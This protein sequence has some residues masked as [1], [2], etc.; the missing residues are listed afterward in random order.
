MEKQSS[1]DIGF[2][3]GMMKS[4]LGMEDLKNAW[5]WLRKPENAWARTGLGAIGGAG[6]GGMMGGTRGAVLG[7]LGGAGLGYAAPDIKDYLFENNILGMQDY[8]HNQ[9][10]ESKYPREQA[11]ADFENSLN[12]IEAQ[13]REA[14]L[15]KYVQQDREKIRQFWKAYF[16]RTKGKR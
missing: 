10:L 8:L 1:Y 9:Y 14:E 13:N 2:Q 3:V 12:E 4:A 11:Q 6:L 15:R 5:H 16:K 7:G